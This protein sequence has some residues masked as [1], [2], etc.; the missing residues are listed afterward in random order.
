[1]P[2]QI[3]KAVLRC[4]LHSLLMPATRAVASGA[5][6]TVG[7]GK[8]PSVWST[9]CPIPSEQSWLTAGRPGPRCTNPL[10]L[11]E[12]FRDAYR[13]ATPADLEALLD[14]IGDE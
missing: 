11:P 2:L 3:S 8:R 10:D 5:D 9:R 4:H 13:A 14:S 7:R 1:M 12:C 6:S